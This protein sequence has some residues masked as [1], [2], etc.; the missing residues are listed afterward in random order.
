MAIDNK[1]LQNYLN[2]FS[3]I[4]TREKDVS[5]YLNNNFTLC[6]PAQVVIDPT[7]LAN[8]VIWDDFAKNDKVDVNPYVLYFGARPYKNNP[9][10]LKQHAER[11]AKDKGYDV[12]TID[13]NH[14]TPLDFVNK[15]RN[16][17]YVVTSSFH[18]VAF[19][20]I[21]NRPLNAILYGDEQDCRYKNL[22]QTIGAEGMLIPAGADIIS[23]SYDYTKINLNLAK[24][25]NTSFDYLNNF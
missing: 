8:P 6:N 2:N 21:F 17:S 10:V 14:D 11:I 16:A 18:G 20:L 9:L 23:Q 15:F 7:L 3:G 12:K 24:L 19:S 22:L 4:S 13:F 1:R 25:R 5:D